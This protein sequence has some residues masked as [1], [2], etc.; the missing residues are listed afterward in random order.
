MLMVLTMMK[1]RRC[2]LIDSFLLF[3]HNPV[4]VFLPCNLSTLSL[5]IFVTLLLRF[6]QHTL[7]LN[8]YS[9]E[10]LEQ[11]YLVMEL[12]AIGRLGWSRV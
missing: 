3:R 8:T 5:I 6:Y 10:K 7:A 9:P 2:F 4:T 11:A 12:S 1:I